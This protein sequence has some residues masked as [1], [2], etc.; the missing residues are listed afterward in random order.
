M[1]CT[2]PVWS[3]LVPHGSYI[4]DIHTE[5]EA[6][7]ILYILST[8]TSYIW[9]IKY[10]I[11]YFKMYCYFNDCACCSMRSLSMLIVKQTTRNTL[12]SLGVM[13]MT[14]FSHYSLI[15]LSL[16]SHHVHIFEGKMQSSSKSSP[17]LVTIDNLTPTNHTKLL[18]WLLFLMYILYL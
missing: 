14:S 1:L 7:D 10:W 11:N 9:I 4:C 16:W 12:T 17:F 6:W 2:L 18:S 15:I 3:S 8:W 13:L 5:L